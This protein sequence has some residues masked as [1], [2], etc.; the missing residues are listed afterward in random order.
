MAPQPSHFS[1][2][3]N[4]KSSSPAVTVL[5]PEP[6]GYHEWHS[7][8]RSR[9]GKSRFY[10]HC[11][12]AP[13]M[14][15]L[16][17]ERGPE[18]LAVHVLCVSSASWVRSS[19]QSV[20]TQFGF[21]LLGS[22]NEFVFLACTFSTY[23]NLI[24]TLRDVIYLSCYPLTWVI[25]VEHNTDRG[26]DLGVDILFIF[27]FHPP[28]S[29]LNSR[30]AKI[31]HL[32]SYL[33]WACSCSIFRRRLMVSVLIPGLDTFSSSKSIDSCYKIWEDYVNPS[34]DFHICNSWS[35]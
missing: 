18:W 26:A 13:S 33:S 1:F 15:R 3:S 25:S 17:E 28:L 20:K 31:L 7:L 16:P 11:S 12:V 21:I 24:C 9:S 22:D 23:E 6:L 2:S 27:I 29:S 5:L 35:T 14:P 8:P 19:L 34:K 32:R 30:S 4:V 10:S